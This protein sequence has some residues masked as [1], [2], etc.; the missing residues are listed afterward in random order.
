MLFL[1]PVSLARTPTIGARVSYAMRASIDLGPRGEVRYSGKVDETVKAVEKD[2]LT[3]AV[4]ATT[5][6]EAMSVSRQGRPI[7]S[8]RVERLDG[9]LVTPAKP[10]EVVLFATTR[11]DRLR[12]F[13][14]PSAP[15][16]IGGAWWHTEGKGEP[17]KSPPFS[18]YLKLE[19]EEKVGV[20]DTWRVSLDA[21]EVEDEHPTHVRAML[22]ID[23]ADGALERGQWQ[24]DGFVYSPTAPPSTAKLELSRTD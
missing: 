13:Y 8:D 24:I 15:V 21:N 18:S 7:L 20:R 16:E 10:D 2:L 6:V 3:T 14:V 12:A 19:G 11:V 5:T 4:E 1:A 23:K 9:T 22:W 17:S